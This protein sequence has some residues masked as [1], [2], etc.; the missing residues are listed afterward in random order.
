MSSGCARPLLRPQLRALNE[1]DFG[2]RLSV[3]FLS[4]RSPPRLCVAR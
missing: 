3:L 1:C 4:L 2:P